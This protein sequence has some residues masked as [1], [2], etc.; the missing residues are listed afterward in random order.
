MC[1]HQESNSN[2]AESKAYNDSS[3]D[4]FLQLGFAGDQIQNEQTVNRYLRTV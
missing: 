3:I 2:A 1:N 4:L